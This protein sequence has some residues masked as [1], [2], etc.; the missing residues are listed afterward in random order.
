MPER[1]KPGMRFRTTTN[2]W[3][4]V[5]KV[6]GTNAVVVHE[7]TGNKYQ[8]GLDALKRLLIEWEE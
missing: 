6:E 4:T 7:R 8:Y 2:E 5:D 1:I 3:F